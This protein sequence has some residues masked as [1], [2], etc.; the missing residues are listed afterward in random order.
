M[1]KAKKEDK[2]KQKMIVFLILE[3][4]ALLLFLEKIHFIVIEPIDHE[5]QVVYQF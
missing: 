1:T 4:E 2:S 5:K 3:K